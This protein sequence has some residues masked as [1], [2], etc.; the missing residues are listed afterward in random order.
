MPKDLIK[1]DCK[2]KTITYPK[3]GHHSG[4]FA[5]I[6][7][8]KTKDKVG[9]PPEK[10]GIITCKGNLPELKPN[11]EYEVTA[12]IFNDPKYGEQ[13]NVVVMNPIIEVN[14]DADAQKLFNY[15]YPDGIAMKLS[16][17]AGAYH[18]IKNE[19]V[20]AL[21][22]IPGIGS[23]TAV[24]LI[25]KFKENLGNT[26]AY[27]ELYNYGLTRRMIENLVQQFGSSE[28]LVGEIK[29]NPYILITKARG[30]GWSKADEIARTGG[31]ANNAKERVV[32][33]IIFYLQK[34]ADDNGHTWIP[35]DEL[36]RETKAYIPTVDND[37]L[38]A[39]LK[40]MIVGEDL[41][42]D[43]PN[44][45]I[46]LKSL[47]KI[48]DEIAKELIRLK[49]APVKPVGDIEKAIKECEKEVGYEYSGEQRAAIKDIMTNNV[50][51]VTANAGC[52]DGETQYFN[53]KE[54]KYIKN[55]TEGERI[56]QY[57]VASKEI[58]M[59][60]PERY[61][62]NDRQECYEIK[63]DNSHL[64]M[65]LSHDH[66]VLYHNQE[67]KYIT[68]TARNFI[69][70]V[71]SGFETATIPTTFNVETV[72]TPTTEE[73]IQKVTLRHF[74]CLAVN[75]TRRPIDEQ[76]TFFL[77]CNKASGNPERFEKQKNI[78]KKFYPQWKECLEKLNEDNRIY[79]YDEEIARL[80]KE[81]PVGD[82]IRNLCYTV[83]PEWW[84]FNKYQLKYALELAIMFMPDSPGRKL[85]ELW[86][87]S[88]EWREFYQYAYA[89]IGKRA[90]CFDD[91][92]YKEWWGISRYEVYIKAD[93]TKGVRNIQLVERHR[94]R[95]HYLMVMDDPEVALDPENIK[96]ERHYRKT[97]CFTT[98]TGYWVARKNGS[99]FITGNCGKSS[100]MYPIVK[101]A[102]NNK[103]NVEQACFSGKASSNL[104]SITHITGKTIHR[105][106]GYRPSSD[107]FTQGGFTYHKDNK[108]PVDIVV[109]DEVSMI[110]ED[111]FLSL[112]RALPD[113]CRLILVGDS[114]QLE[115]I[116]VG[117]VLK[118][119]T[120]SNVVTNN[121]LTKI[122]RQAARSGIIT[123]SLKIY[124]QENFLGEGS[125]QT[126]GE[127]QDFDII[128]K[129]D[130][131]SV[132]RE[133]TVKYLEL[134][135]SGISAKDMVIATAKRALGPTSAR[136]L[137]E[138]CQMIA[139][140]GNEETAVTVERDE[141]GQT[142]EVKFKVKDQ[143]LVTKNCYTTLNTDNEL[144]PIFNGN[145]G[146]IKSID[147]DHK[148]MVTH[149]NGEDVVL[150][151]PQ[152]QNID[153]GY[154]ITTHKLQ[155]SGVS[156]VIVVCDNSAY[157]LLSKEWLYTAITRAKKYCCLISERSAIKK[158]LETTRVSSKHTWLA[159]LLMAY[160]AKKEV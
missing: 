28:I 148:I 112:L 61:I 127:L 130:N 125:T 12:E 68:T 160:A 81:D 3:S 25:A 30:I 11:V 159:E 133:A 156:H 79:W 88:P 113:G 2:I 91:E 132:A 49:N 103:L 69:T 76:Y 62:V 65:S 137:N 14:N 157:V 64:Y 151:Y 147:K 108:L 42:Y 45:R 106:L 48:E 44:R 60:K 36:V 43:K 18:L 131:E 31:M 116:G 87:F 51:V 47:Y 114:G 75:G 123:D 138:T 37:N 67:N 155:G 110:A 20:E 7:V 128:L 72:G 129:G 100:M 90:V 5:I 99:I 98:L 158:C 27:V 95:R 63:D 153:L 40:E 140:R 124:N 118:D 74:A 97:Y 17:V 121:K 93:G 29:K 117:C 86:T 13:C 24:K 21:S 57:N 71:L 15:I 6:K 16:N 89:S 66:R 139:N 104:T 54:W 141:N 8:V 105:L 107:E 94:R 32:A 145:I 122:F 101:M 115:P 1:F 38:A 26:G 70:S 152:W 154:A 135:R 4:D 58:L 46:G 136:A 35:L 41:V 23:K 85:F 53:G 33:F 77:M 52:V 55:Y 80:Y 92:Q 73:K 111:I 96:I 82:S 59:R 119:I 84:R 10:M 120:S 22:K 34:Q 83:P 144:C 9:T 142:Y 19:D 78:V 143:I 102:E 109:L 39:Y 149:I 126:H 50:S 150:P 56:M 146:T 134:F